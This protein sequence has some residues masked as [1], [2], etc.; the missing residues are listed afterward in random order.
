MMETILISIS[1]L[2][3]IVGALI[4]VAKSGLEDIHGDD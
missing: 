1:I 2:I 4:L 3:L